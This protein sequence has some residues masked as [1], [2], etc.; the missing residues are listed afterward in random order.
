MNLAGN[1]P[2]FGWISPWGPLTTVGPWAWLG[3][4]QVAAGNL[5]NAAFS[6]TRSKALVAR[7]AEDPLG[8]AASKSWSQAVAN[9]PDG[10]GVSKNFMALLGNVNDFVNGTLDTVSFGLTRR[11]RES[12]SEMLDALGL[13]AVGELYGYKTDYSSGAYQAGGYAG[14]VVNIALTLA[15]PGAGALVG[16][17]KAAGAAGALVNAGEA[18]LNG[19]WKGALLG[20]AA[21]ATMGLSYLNSCQVMG[22]LGG[23]LSTVAN[24]G[25]RVLGLVG[26]VS[27]VESAIE[28]FGNGDILGG[29]LDLVQAGADLYKVGDLNQACFT[30]RMLIDGAFGKKRADQ[31]KKGDRVWARNEFHPHGQLALKRVQQVFRRVSPVWNLHVAGQIIETTPEHPFYVLGKGWLPVAWLQ[32]GDFLYTRGGLLVAVEGVADSGRVQTVYNWRIADYHTYFVSATEQGAAIW[33]HNAKKSYGTIGAGPVKKGQAGVKKT[34][35]TAKA[36][37]ETVRGEE[38]T[39]ELPSGNRTRADVVTKTKGKRTK[40]RESKNGPNADLTDGQKEMQE[41]VKK[42]QPVIPRGKRAKNA[43]F[44]PGVPV[45]IDLFQIDRW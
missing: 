17:L 38:V 4:M 35:K 27:S 22:A 34:L 45:I 7:K 13:G 5:V 44:T 1:L 42:K 26:A 30:G 21:A 6:S 41:A 18:A 19:D 2:G 33:A 9:L 24:V 37:G 39:F 10:V 8:M 20:A 36:A 28:R 12:T 32:I 14:Q 40:I 29:V 11:L 3:Q 23:P 43:G 25:I 15:G 31:I 16:A